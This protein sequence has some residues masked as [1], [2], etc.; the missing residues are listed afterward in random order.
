MRVFCHTS[1]YPFIDFVL[2]SKEKQFKLHHQLHSKCILLTDS[3]K[4]VVQKL[5]TAKMILLDPDLFDAWTDIVLFLQEKTSLPIKLFVIADSDISLCND[6]MDALF[7]YFPDTEF[8]IQNWL[9]GHEQCQ[10]LPIGASRPFDV[11]SAP[12]SRP[13]LCS[14]AKGY[15]SSVKRSEYLKWLDTFPE[16]KTYSQPPLDFSDYLQTVAE[17]KYHTC[18]MGMGYDTFRFW[19]SLALGAIPIVKEHFFYERLKAFFPDAPTVYVSSWEEV[20]ER[21]FSFPEV[22]FPSLPYLF[23]DYWVTKCQTLLEGNVKISKSTA[24]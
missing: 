20:P 1:L 13:L 3:P 12:K 22:S 17:A 10:L 7:A 2:T 19:E 9:G 15:E 11:F 6:H 14:F 24:C 4:E 18:P 5:S 21:L 8:W 16:K 23:E